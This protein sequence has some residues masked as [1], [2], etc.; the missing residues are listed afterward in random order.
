MLLKQIIAVP[1]DQVSREENQFLI[2][3]QIYG[4]VAE[5]DG[6]GRKILV[7]KTEIKELKP[8]QYMV[9]SKFNPNSWDSRYFGPVEVVNTYEKV[10]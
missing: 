10:W 5:K 3:D 8:G 1:G 6:M 4:E 9:G 7:F 2:N